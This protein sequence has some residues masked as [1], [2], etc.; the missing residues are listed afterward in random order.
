[1]TELFPKELAE[2]TTLKND[3][4]KYRPLSKEQVDLLNQDIRL[5]LKR[6]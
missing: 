2:L 3:M 5:D 6:S 4:A 1:M